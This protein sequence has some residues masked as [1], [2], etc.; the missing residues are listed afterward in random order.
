M[1]DLP[2]KE[3]VRQSIAHYLQQLEGASC[4]NIYHMVLSEMEKGLLEVVMQHTKGNQSQ[5]AKRLGL[6]RNTVRKLLEKHRVT[7]T[8]Q[9]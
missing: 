2:L 7:G 6:S 1:P 9:H 8:T 4:S 5:A 3:L